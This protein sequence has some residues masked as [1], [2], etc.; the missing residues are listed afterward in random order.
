MLYEF[1]DTVPMT[2]TTET[3]KV[4]PS[5]AV[6][7]NGKYLEDLIDGYQTLF[8]TGRELIAPEVKTKSI[9]AQHGSRIKQRRYQE[10]TIKVCFRLT[11]PNA[12]ELMQKF[13]ILTGVLN[14]Q[15]ATFIFNDEPDKFFIGTPSGCEPPDPGRNFIKAEWYIL[16]NDPFK[17]TINVFE[18]SPEKQDDGTNLISVENAGTTDTRP[19]F[20]IS[21]TR[22]C[23]YI[24]FYDSA[25]HV[26][27]FGNPDEADG[28]DIGSSETLINTTFGG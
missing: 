10:R 4:Y 1:T 20:D 6:T 21:F 24:A 13:N 16:C 28:R 15:D 2:D 9:G 8:T 14:T 7:I 19:V 5:E 17:R 11:A 25:N 27:Q 26:L 23:G 3:E 18:A 12:G 22:D